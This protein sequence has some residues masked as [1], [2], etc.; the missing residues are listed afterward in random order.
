M[1][2]YFVVSRK[3]HFILLHSTTCFHSQK[4]F[5]WKA[6]NFEDTSYIV[7]I[8]I[9]WKYTEVIKQWI[10]NKLKTLSRKKKRLIPIKISVLDR[11]SICW[12]F[13]SFP[14]NFQALLG[15]LCQPVSVFLSRVPNQKT[16]EKFPFSCLEVL[17]I[18]HYK[19]LSHFSSR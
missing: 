9:V 18:D 14:I 17:F 6:I 10:E 5:F 11:L 1:M 2:E 4:K 12:R 7:V 15:N 3:I 16:L 8:T 13:N 19:R